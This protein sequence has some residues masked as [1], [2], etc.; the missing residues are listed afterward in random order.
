M[1]HLTLTG[2]LMQQPSWERSSRSHVPSSRLGW[3]SITSCPFNIDSQR[4]TGDSCPQRIHP[5]FCPSFLLQSLKV[6]W[7]LKFSIQV[8]SLFDGDSDTFLQGCRATP[9]FMWG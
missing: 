9:C 6:S 4:F 7:G 1:G 5:S 8:Y 2:E 3:V